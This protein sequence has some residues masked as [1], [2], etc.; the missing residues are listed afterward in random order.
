MQNVLIYCPDQ[1]ARAVIARHFIQIGH[2]QQL[3]AE[4][5]KLTL[6]LVLNNDIFLV[7]LCG[8]ADN[9]SLAWMKDFIRQKRRRTRVRI[10][11]AKS[12]QLKESWREVINAALKPIRPR[13][14]TML[15]AHPR[16]AWKP[17]PEAQ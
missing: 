9:R 10:L 14:R 1:E 5:E 2:F 7:V 3:Y 11:P 6:S 12:G 17:S 8:R 13:N 15:R 16:F 4:T